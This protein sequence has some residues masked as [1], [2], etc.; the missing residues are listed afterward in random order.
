MFSKLKTV[1]CNMGALL[2]Y[3]RGH[4]VLKLTADQELIYCSNRSYAFRF[5]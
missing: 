3:E 5:G 4:M 1:S 2:L